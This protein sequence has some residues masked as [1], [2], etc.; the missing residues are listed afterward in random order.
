MC[1]DVYVFEVNST[2]RVSSIWL[3]ASDELSQAKL[4]V[5]LVQSVGSSV[6]L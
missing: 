4:L 3:F 2:G 1:V 5:Y 6:R